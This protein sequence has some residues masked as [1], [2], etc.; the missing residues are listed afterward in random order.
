LRNWIISATRAPEY[1]PDT[2]ADRFPQLNE[3]KAASQTGRTL[4]ALADAWHTHALSRGVRPRDAKRWKAVAL[5]FKEW[6]CH[7]DLGRVTPERVQA[8]GEE[9]NAQ[10]IA[11]KTIN[12]TDF[13]ALRAV[14]KRGKQRGWLASNPAAEARIEGRGKTITRERYFSEQEIAAIRRRKY[15]LSEP[16]RLVGQANLKTIVQHPCVTGAARKTQAYQ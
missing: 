11:A 3:V 12:D 2:Y 10:G 14:F 1:R 16:G 5:R 9:R 13:A 4:T 8:W 15:Q 7:D 6:L